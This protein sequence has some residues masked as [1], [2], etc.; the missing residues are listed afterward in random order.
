MAA[1]DCLALQEV[2]HEVM[3]VM[4]MVAMVMGPQWHFLFLGRLLINHQLGSDRYP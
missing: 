1:P 4:A 2:I 3:G